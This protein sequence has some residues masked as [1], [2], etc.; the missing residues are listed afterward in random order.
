LTQEKMVKT[1]DL[2]DFA[3]KSRDES[4]PDIIF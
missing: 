1:S 2:M 4:G 3:S